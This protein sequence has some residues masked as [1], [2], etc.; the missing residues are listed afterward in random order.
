MHGFIAKTVPIYWGSP[1]VALDFEEGAY[2]SRHNYV[3]DNNF[4][5]AI[6][7]LDQDK[8]DWEMMANMDP[9]TK[10]SQLR[11]WDLDRFNQW[12]LENVYKGVRS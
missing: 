9:I 12:F 6:I 10:K 2:I 7:S 3:S 4:I 5:D 11:T 8:S 1:T